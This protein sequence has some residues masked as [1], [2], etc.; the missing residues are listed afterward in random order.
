LFWGRVLARIR[1]LYRMVCQSN[2]SV[3]EQRRDSKIANEAHQTMGKLELSIFVC[4]QAV[5]ALRDRNYNNPASSST[6]FWAFFLRP[7][8]RRLRLLLPMEIAPLAS[9]ADFMIAMVWLQPILGG[10][11]PVTR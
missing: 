11:K 9:Q 2:P 8:V 6:S 4:Q 1:I 3:A 10:N 7:K 5:C